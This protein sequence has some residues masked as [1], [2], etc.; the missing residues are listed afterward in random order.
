MK[1]SD[2]KEKS[3]VFFIGKGIIV[4][5]LTGIASLSFLLGFFV[6]KIS[7]APEM[8][9]P[10]AITAEGNAEENIPVSS[11]EEPLPLQ[12][13][14]LQ[15]EMQTPHDAGQRDATNTIQTVSE[16]QG[17]PQPHAPQQT[18]ELQKSSVNSQAK[19]NQGFKESNAASETK[20][21]DETNISDKTKKYTVQVGAFRNA[22]DA[23]ALRS[24]L[25]EKGHKTF[26][27]ELKT[28][29][30]EPLYKVAVGAFRTR[31]EAELLA[32]KM[33]KSEGLKT[34]VTLR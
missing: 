6:G 28:K 22:S 9:Q 24:K 5:V 3:S 32:A 21:P 17:V 2:L 4:I 14:P 8:D 33:K 15:G 29:N 13:D 31:S 26:L 11:G 10:S 7:R 20:K 25:D 1:Q 23:D 19:Q 18:N 27:I 12:A 34:F 30:N 16:T